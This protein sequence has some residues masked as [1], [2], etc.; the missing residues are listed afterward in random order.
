MAPET[1]ENS[2]RPRPEAPPPAHLM[3]AVAELRA[4]VAALNRRVEDLEAGQAQGQATTR[5]LALDVADFGRSLT[6][7]MRGVESRVNQRL[8]ALA[9]VAP[10]VPGPDVSDIGQKRR[11]RALT[12][13]IALCLLLAGGAVGALLFKTGAM[14]PRSSAADAPPPRTTTIPPAP[15]VALHDSGPLP[16]TPSQAGARPAGGGVASPLNSLA[17][18]ASAPEGGHLLYG[19]PAQPAKP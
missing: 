2:P 5:Q 8:D 18:P 9:P 16:A 13:L 14:S 4:T 7:R 3:V 6:D 1:L 10:V 17:P 12:A 11:Q 19:V 15:V